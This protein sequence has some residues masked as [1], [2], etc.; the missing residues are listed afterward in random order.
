MTLWARLAA[1]VLVLALPC[2]PSAFAQRADEAQVRTA[3]ERYDRRE[4]VGDLAFRNVGALTAALSSVGREWTES[5]PAAERTRRQEVVALFVLDLALADVRS[6]MG[7]LDR[8]AMIEWACDWLKAVPRNEFHLLWQRA[9][10]AVLQLAGVPFGDGSR[11]AD[12]HLAH[13]LERFPSDGRLRLADLLTRPVAWALSN[14]PGARE[15]LL[16]RSPTARLAPVSVKQWPL[17]ATLEAFQALA[18]DPAV[19]SEAQAHAGIILFHRGELSHA[20]SEL[21]TAAKRSADPFV[22]NLAWLMAGLTQ[23]AERK[24]D[25]AAVSY[26]RAFEAIPEAKASAT[27]LAWSWFNAGRREEASIVLDRSFVVSPPMLDPWQRVADMMRFVPA[28]VAE[29]H[30]LVGHG[31]ALIALA[32]APRFETPTTAKDENLADTLG[33][34]AS[35]P[36]ATDQSRP[37][38]RSVTDGVLV[39]LSVFAGR[40]PVAD[41]KASDVELFDNGVLQHIDELVTES[42][43]LD[44]SMVL[45]YYDAGT[46][47]ASLNPLSYSREQKRQLGL[48]ATNVLKLFRSGDRVRI[49]TVENEPNEVVHLTPALEVE[50]PQEPPDKVLPKMSYGRSSAIYDAVGAVLMRSTP[51]GRRHLVLTFSEGVDDAS[52]MTANRLLTIASRADAVMHLSKRKTALEIAQERTL[53]GRSS[54]SWVYSNLLWPQE[55]GVLGEAC[56]LTG[57]TVINSLGGSKYEEVLQIIERLRSSYL[58]RYQATGV[59]PRGWH[60]IEVRI[61]RP[62]K[63][64]IMAR[65]GYWGG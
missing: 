22:R 60:R 9:S 61:R 50:I 57:G 14:R 3:L 8:V 36:R 62:G 7:S 54:F 15:S 12:A 25:L 6:G 37:S 23:D 34:V 28:W 65:K 30:Q 63:F 55:P 45:D 48:D 20:E 11:Q 17:K 64:T 29:M 31:Q 39:D 26:E 1:A 43:P 18:T 51:M 24:P 35:I 5:V 58:I 10:Y 41:L 40:N 46:W 19:G 56:R 33:V 13:A 27:A 38:F 42:L 21:I 59:E 44:L 4:A 32:A 16:V 52:V 47:G 49:V 2:G 53:S